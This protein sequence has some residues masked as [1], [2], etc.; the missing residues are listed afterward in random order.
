MIKRIVWS[1][2]VSVGIG[3]PAAA[4]SDVLILEE[5]R[6]GAFV[7]PYLQVLEDPSNSWSVSDANIAFNTTEPILIPPGTGT[8]NFGISESSYW[9]AIDVKSASVKDVEWLLEIE[10]PLLD[11]VHFYH[12]DEHGDWNQ[13]TA[14]DLVPFGVREIQHPTLLFPFTINA[15]DETR[16]LVS[17]KTEGSVQLPARVWRPDD[18][19]I[20]AKNDYIILGIYYG[21]MLA[22]GFY[23]LFIFFAVRD[24]SYLYYI[25]Y[26]F[27]IALYT[28]ANKGLG[29]QYLWP[30][31][32]GVGTY[33]VTTS[34]YVAAFFS[35]LFCKSYLH[36]KQNAPR[37]DTTL[38]VM[39]VTTLLSLLLP[40]VASYQ[41]AIVLGSLN[42]LIVAF[43]LMFSGFWIMLQGQR[44]ARY[45][46]FAWLVFLIAVIM[47][48][49]QRL[50]V[51]DGNFVIEEGVLFG[52]SIEVILLSL[53][54]ADRINTLRREKTVVQ[55]EL[56]QRNA[57]T[58]AALQQASA[59][60]DEF[61]ANVFH[62]LRTPLTG[63]V[64]LTDLV[65][66]ANQTDLDRDSR[67]NLNMIRSS[68]QRLTSLVN[69]IVDISAINRNYLE[70]DR[71]S[72]DLNSTAAFVMAMCRPM[73]GAKP[74]ELRVDLPADLPLV[75]ADENRMAQVFFNLVAN[76]IKFTPRGA[77]TIS[78]GVSGK[79]VEVCVADTGI[80]I[81]PEKLDEIFEPFKQLNGG[82]D[83][84]VGGTGLG[85]S[86]TRKIIELHDSKINVQSTVGDGTRFLF[87]LPVAEDQDVL[88]NAEQTT[89]ELDLPELEIAN[90][91]LLPQESLPE[92]LG[93]SSHTIIIVD[94]EYAN[95]HILQEF[96][97]PYAEV[98]IAQDGFEALELLKT[99]QPDLL[100][101][102]LMMPQMSG[103]ELCTR[104]RSSNSLTELPI[105]ILTAKKQ[106]E[107][108]VEGLRAGANDYLSKPFHRE[109]L[110]ARVQKLLQLKDLVEIRDR[111]QRL[112]DQIDRFK[113]SEQKLRT[114]QER[115][116][117]M[118]DY[119][120]EN[121][122]CVD[123]AGRITHITQPAAEFL[124]AD[125]ASLLN[126]KIGA[127]ATENDHVLGFPFK[128]SII[129]ADALPEF[130]RCD[131][132]VGENE[133]TAQ[134][135]VLSLDLEQE[136]YVVILQA[137]NERVA[138]PESMHLIAEVNKNVQRAQIL[139]AQLDQITPALL[140][141]EP[142]LIKELEKIDAII[143]ALS[144][145]VSVSLKEQEF[146]L[147]LV[148][149]M[150]DCVNI[151]QRVTQKTVI[152]LAEE[153]GVWRINIDNGRLRARSM[154][155]YLDINKLPK[156]PRW[157]EV[158]RTA[159][160]ILSH[161][162]LTESDR[163]D[164]EMQ[165]DRLDQS[166]RS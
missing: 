13:L 145:T 43:L 39:A 154:E 75:Y 42:A 51:V 80:G 105:L 138:A 155:R 96:L 82:I 72:V 34:A 79:S 58:I 100:I 140:Q 146:R 46:F 78:A 50:G 68:S 103:Y 115:L 24:V 29:S 4:W 99:H 134:V 114:S 53:G 47:I 14:G 56:L 163:S 94:D 133:K 8:P 71:R 147:S 113:E 123:A 117:A 81:A 153:S 5:A 87:L 18:F 20:E 35:I 108:L 149:L 141:D 19:A 166:G 88:A 106:T 15:G 70:V 3:L 142:S 2:L 164:L 125:K 9:F 122:L 143:S 111:N 69:D 104:V 7:S 38:N 21:I 26:V 156:K 73:I 118:L 40:M 62:E 135:C 90:A 6:S 54:L 101:V 27:H 49:L 98:L 11:V 86:I 159:Y 17:V 127:L 23:N 91:A 139:G 41:T 66:E 31:S 52:T 151:W 30:D 130:F 67:V 107:D 97:K 129:S 160:F 136:F 162:E 112:Q 65:L 44:A 28:F 144:S 131:I 126:E 57:E 33:S 1:V 148:K 55:Q 61:V 121:I 32:P 95:L 92:A 37:L 157:R 137:D 93:D 165:T 152:D 22:L 161:L 110:I 48:A 116:A 150:Q 128:E 16:L 84:T 36:V 119:G 158:T 102:D 64:G 25:L 12:Q 120:D 124:S 60:K 132:R 45:F 89:I 10:Y 63:I 77:V 109:E 59:I 76:A 85:L 83:R 74:V